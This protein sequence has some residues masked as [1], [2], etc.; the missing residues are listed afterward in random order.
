M[1]SYVPIDIRKADAGGLL[2]VI[3][4]QLF[5]ESI[6]NL[7][8]APDYAVEIRSGTE[9]LYGR[10]E[11]ETGQRAEY[12]ERFQIAANGL[13]WQ[14]NV[15]PTE[16]ALKRESLWIPRLALIVGFLMVTLLAVAVHLAQTS[17]IRAGALE[18]E[19][20]DRVSAETALR[21][22][23][24][25]YRS[26]IENLEQGVFLKGA[27]GSYLAVNTSYCRRLGKTE[28]EI[29]GHKDD[30]FASSEAVARW[31]EQEHEVLRTGKT[32]ETE[33][34]TM[35]GNVKKRGSPSVYSVLSGT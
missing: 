7:N 9:R 27:D 1:I 18:I 21:R 24:G 3:S 34:E 19:I 31:D 20:K 4:L 2:A 32:I 14:F 30:S 11:N 35:L 12:E 28:S 26:L 23:E 17:R 8:V 6:L 15:W 33:E 13:D 16:S 25:K 22:S 29:V 5:L 10:L